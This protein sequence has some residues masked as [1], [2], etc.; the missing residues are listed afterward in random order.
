MMYWVIYSDRE[1]AYSM[2]KIVTVTCLFIR[3]GEDSCPA[4]IISGKTLAQSS[5][6]CVESRL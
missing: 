2:G 1:S 4:E 3:L 5:K 6:S